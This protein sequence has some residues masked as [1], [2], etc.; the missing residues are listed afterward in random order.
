MRASGA[1]WRRSRLGIP[2]HGG[3][4]AYAN[5]IV[6]ATTIGLPLTAIDAKTNRVL[7][8]WVGPGGDA[9]KVATDRS[10]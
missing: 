5:G 3:D 1:R 10:G 9:L 7:V 2:G 8:Q 6:W 4:I